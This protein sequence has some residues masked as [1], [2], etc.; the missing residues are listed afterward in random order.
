MTG[1]SL[2]VYLSSTPASVAHGHGRVFPWR[3]WAGAPVGPSSGSQSGADRHPDAW[4]PAACDRHALPN[5]LLRRAIRAFSAGAGGRCHR[6]PL[7]T[8]ILPRCAAMRCPCSRLSSPHGHGHRLGAWALPPGSARR[9]KPC[10]RLRP[11]KSVTAGVAMGISE[12]L[13]GFARPHGGSRHRHGHHRGYRGHAADEWF[14]HHQSPPRA[15]LQSVWPAH[16]IGTARAF[17]V[18]PVAGVFAAWPWALCHSFGRACAGY[19][20]AATLTA[21]IRQA[22]ASGLSS[23]CGLFVRLSRM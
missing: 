17:A 8:G 14:A 6:L 11:N 23:P 7:Y 15:A 10:W 19:R 20:R 22:M 18:S 21:P 12:N 13:G 9:K 1:P 4:S 5:L 3:G 2:W 16:G